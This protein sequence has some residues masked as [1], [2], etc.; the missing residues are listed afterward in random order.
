MQVDVQLAIADTAQW[1]LPAADMIETW[2]TAAMVAGRALTEQAQVAD[3]EIAHD[4]NR[5]DEHMTVRIVELDEIATLNQ[6]YRQKTGATNVLSFPFER[7][8]GLPADACEES[9][10]DLVVCAAVVT[11]EAAAQQKPLEAHWAHMIMHGTLHLLGYDHL[12]DEEARQMETLE[13][14]VLSTFGYANPYE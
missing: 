14:S 11:Q 9:L 4:A 1:R 5:L 3:P 6:Q 13:I 7:P 12:T 8:P 2:A 10:G